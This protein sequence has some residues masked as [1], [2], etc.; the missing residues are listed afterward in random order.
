MSNREKM[1]K[2]VQCYSFA[3]L[4]AAMFLD[5][6]PECLD[7]LNYYNKYKKLCEE[8]KAEFEAKYGPLTIDSDANN[9]SW[10]WVNGPWPWELSANEEA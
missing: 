4:E 3:V 9:Q 7:A 1:L 2:M 6:H 8:A 5:T 10:Q